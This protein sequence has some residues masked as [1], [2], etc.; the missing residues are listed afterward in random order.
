MYHTRSTNWRPTTRYDGSTLI[1]LAAVTVLGWPLPRGRWRSRPLLTLAR[2]SLAECDSQAL[3][4]IFLELFDYWIISR[5]GII[6]F[7]KRTIIIINITENVV[8]SS[9]WSITWCLAWL[10]P[11]HQ[12]PVGGPALPCA[13]RPSLTNNYAPWWRLGTQ[14]LGNICLYLIQL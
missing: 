11:W 10:C 5:N 2:Q 1:F 12:G 3:L 14:Q 6:D 7:V 4:Y 9:S 13:R 8:L